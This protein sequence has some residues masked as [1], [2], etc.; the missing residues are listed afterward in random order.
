MTSKIIAISG[1]S[2]CGNTTVSKL[3]AKRLNIEIINYTFRTLAVD[4]GMSF[5]HL[6][7]EAEKDYSYDRAVDEKQVE[8]ARAQDCVVGSRLAMWLLTEAVL[9]VYL[10]ASPEIRAS[11]IRNREGKNLQEIMDFTALRDHR[12]HERYLALYGIDND[13][14]SHADLIINTERFAPEAEAEIIVAAFKAKLGL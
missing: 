11:R 12:D 7:E 10:S 6:L 5:E 4:R 9:K 1:K 14:Y 13:S 8:L 2:G 3:V